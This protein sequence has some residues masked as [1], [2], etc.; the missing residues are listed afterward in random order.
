MRPELQQSTET[1]DPTQTSS[2]QHDEAAGCTQSQ[3]IHTHDSKAT[4]DKDPTQQQ[5][6]SLRQKPNLRCSWAWRTNAWVAD[7]KQHNNNTP[8]WVDSD[9]CCLNTWTQHEPLLF[10]N[11]SSAVDAPTFSASCCCRLLSSAAALRCCSFR[12]CSSIFLPR[13]SAQRSSCCC[14]RR[15]LSCSSWGSSAGAAQQTGFRLLSPKRQS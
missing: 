7:C 1:E 9:D 4:A 11:F 12:R 13:S 5:P 15:S 2:T 10:A 8:C 14:T 3:G 6:Q